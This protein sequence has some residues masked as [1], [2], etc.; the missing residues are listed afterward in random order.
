MTR[1]TDTLISQNN[2]LGKKIVI[3]FK[4]TFAS[5]LSENIFET[6]TFLKS[7]QDV[8]IPIRQAMECIEN[9]FTVKSIQFPYIC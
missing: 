4:S 7:V 3:Y 8:V 2:N 5:L 1:F 6:T 9:L